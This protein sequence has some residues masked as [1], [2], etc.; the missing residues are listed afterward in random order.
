MRERDEKTKRTR[1]A[2]EELTDVC[3]VEEQTECAERERE[4]GLCLCLFV[5]RERERERER[6]VNS[7]IR[8]LTRH[9]G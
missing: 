5:E 6:E 1:T 2:S 8:S 7:L 3:I 4:E 9:D